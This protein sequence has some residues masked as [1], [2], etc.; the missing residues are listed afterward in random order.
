M[1]ESFILASHADLVEDPA[2][3]LQRLDRFLARFPAVSEEDRRKVREAI[4]GSLH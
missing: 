4:L 1:I 2:Q 3:A